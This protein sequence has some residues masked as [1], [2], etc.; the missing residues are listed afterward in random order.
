LPSIDV[1]RNLSF[2]DILDLQSA[3]SAE[4]I[5]RGCWGVIYKIQPR[6]GAWY[7]L[8][9]SKCSPETKEVSEDSGNRDLIEY[10]LLAKCGRKWP[11]IPIMTEGSILEDCVLHLLDGAVYRGPSVCLTMEYADGD[12][13]RIGPELTPEE[14]ES[15]ALQIMLAVYYIQSVLV[16]VHT[17]IKARNVLY[18]RTR[19]GGCWAYDVHGQ[20]VFVRNE[21]F[22]ALLGD[23]GC[24]VC[25]DAGMDSATPLSCTPIGTRGIFIDAAP[26]GGGLAVARKVRCGEMMHGSGHVRD[27][28][29]PFR[30]EWDDGSESKVAD[31]RVVPLSQRDGC[32][33]PMFRNALGL[34]WDRMYRDA[35]SFPPLEFLTDTQ[36]VLAMFL[37][38][39]RFGNEGGDH[40]DLFADRYSNKKRSAIL[41]R[42]ARY[43]HGAPLVRQR[44]W[45][46]DP[47]KIL[48]SRF[49]LAY[50][51]EPRCDPTKKLGKEIARYSFPK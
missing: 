45:P 44:I 37:G 24:A 25:L 10:C 43:A 46:L 1:S 33:Y 5:G 39:E 21:G 31:L 30:V 20:S 41:H 2:G 8:K 38:T 11:N 40:V 23:F 28:F 18:T 27:G 9:L 4:I 35:E 7:V 32:K 16:T 48:A 13:E 22:V 3:G 17:D 15:F 36:D 29:F 49:L 47:S 19:R 14:M 26:E 6:K 34:D 42:L 12:L 51:V 50:T